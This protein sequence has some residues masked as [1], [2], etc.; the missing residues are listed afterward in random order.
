DKRKFGIKGTEGVCCFNFPIGLV[1]E[2]GSEV[3]TIFPDGAPFKGTV[4][5][6]C[7]DVGDTSVVKKVP[8]N[9]TQAEATAYTPGK[10]VTGPVPAD[11]CSVCLTKES[12]VIAPV[13]VSDLTPQNG[14]IVTNLTRPTILTVNDLN[15]RSG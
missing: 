1:K 4:P 3:Q 9:S 8:N 2:D 11:A 12:N 7:P 13:K 10:N 5:H 15:F 14:F 6:G